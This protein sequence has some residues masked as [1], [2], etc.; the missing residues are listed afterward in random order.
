MKDRQANKPNRFKIAFEDTSLGNKWATLTLDDEPT[1][2]GT[3]L[4]STTLCNGELLSSL[5]LAENATPSEAMEALRDYNTIQTY[6]GQLINSVSDTVAGLGAITIKRLTSTL[7]EIHVECRITQAATS[8]SDFNWGI[9]VDFLNKAF[10]QLI[11]QPIE[12]GNW[13]IMG[14]TTSGMTPPD[15]YGYA[16]IWLANNN[17]FWTPGR[18]YTSE[19]NPGAWASNVFNKDCVLSGT[20]YAE[21][22]ENIFG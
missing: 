17:K 13:Y 20:I 5:S 4:N 6:R 21:V 2:V 14:G 19:G 11:F 8:S 16:S 9:N 12:G 1:E 10:P 22:S 15:I 3:P 18:I 7:C